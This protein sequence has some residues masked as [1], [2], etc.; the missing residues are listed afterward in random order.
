MA[1]QNPVTPLGVDADGNSSASAPVPAAA[2]IPTGTTTL[3]SRTT[4]GDGTITASPASLISVEAKV[5]HATSGAVA[6]VIKL[7]GTFESAIPTDKGDPLATFILSGTDE[8]R[9][10]L[11]VQHMFSNLYADVSGIS[12]TTTATLTVGA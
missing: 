1:I 11:T 7:Y 8:H 10:N 6:G 12:G 9:G 2:P 3:L 4:N 5:V